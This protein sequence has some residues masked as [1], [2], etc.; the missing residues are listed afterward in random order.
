MAADPFLGVILHATGGLAAASFYLPYKAVRKWGWENYWLAGGLFAWIIA[1]WAISLSIIPDT[2]AI[3]REAPPRTLFWTWF[4][5]VLWGIGG[6]T[7][8]LT[9]RYLGIALGYALA[10]GLC[11]V[12]G[13]LIPPIFAGELGA[14]AGSLPG[15]VVLAG[16]FVCV[17][18]IACSGR[19]G[20][21][22]EAK[23]ADGSSQAHQEYNFGKGALVAVFAGVMSASMSFG[24]T[25][26]KPIGAI[27]VEHGAPELWQNLPVLVVVLLG[28]FMTNCTWCVYQ[29]VKKGSL[30]DYVAGGDSPFWGNLALCVVAGVTWYFQFFFYGMGQTKMGKYE[31]SSWTLH[32]ASIIIFGTVWGLLLREW[33][34]T[35]RRT[36]AWIAAGLALLIGS[37][38][39]VGYG[40]ALAADGGGPAAGDTLTLEEQFVGLP[41][42]AKRLTGPLFWLHGDESKERLEMYVEKV[43]EG[44]NG[45]FTAESRP[46]S[47]WLGEGWYRDLEIC[48]AAAKKHDLK[49]WIFDEMWWPSQGVAGKVPGRYATKKM[50]TSAVEV[51]GPT[52]WRGE[53]YGGERYIAA[54]AGRVAADGKI[55]GGSLVDMAGHITDG[56]L[57][58]DV[59]E[60]TWRI[61]KFTHVQGP[62]LGQ[63]GQLS[64]DGAS[65]DCVDWFIETVYQPH[66]DR[67]KEDFGMWIPG[68]FYDE[69]ET[70]GDWGTELNATLAEWGVDWKKAYV[71]YK[72]ELSGEKQAAAKYQY[73]DAFAETWGRTMYGTLTA[74]CEERGVKSIGHFMEHGSLY[75]HPEFCAGDMMRLQK[76]SSMGGIDAVFKQFIMGRKR[77]GHD[78]PMWQTPKLGS[79]ISHVYGKPDD[80]AMVEIFGARGQ[81]LTYPEMKWWIDHMQVSGIN[82]TIPH[83][84]NPRAP[85]DT[86][87]PPY[88]Y[89]GGHEPRW[90]LYRVLADYSSRLTLLLTG[91]R[92]VC[93]A[94]ILFGGN[95]R[96]VG[97]AV[98]PE[99]MTTAL[100]DALFD[101]DWLPFEVFERDTKLVGDEIAL[102]QERYKVLIVPPVEVIPYASLA[103]AKAF[104]D[105]GGVVVG[106]GFLPSKSATL[107]KTAEDIA[108][109]RT[110]IWGNA[111]AGLK[112]CRTNAAGG[113]SYLLAE[114][115]TPEDLTQALWKDAGVP[116]TVEVLE[117]ETNDWVHA[118]HRVKDGRDIFFIT[119]QN[120]D[121][122]VRLRAGLRAAGYPERWDA[123]RGEITSAAFE[124]RGDVAEMTLELEPFESV[125]I[126]FSAEQRALPAAV[127][128]AM[129][130]VAAVDV[131]RRQGAAE[132]AAAAIVEQEKPA[133][134]DC[135]WV[136][137]GGGNPAAAAAVGSCYFRRVVDIDTGK[138]VAS[139][140]LIINAD[141]TAVPF[142]NGV[143]L[144]DGRLDTWQAVSD[145]DITE[146][147][148]PGG[149]V[150]AV[151]V[152]NGGTEPNPAG[153]IGKVVVAFADG[154]TITVRIDE[155]W[156]AA[157]TAPA[158]WT[159]N[160]FDDKGWAAAVPFA[161]YGQSPWGDMSSRRITRSPIE[162]ADPFDGRFVVPAGVDIAQVR[163][164]L[165]M[166]GIAPEAAARITINGAYAGGVIERPLRLDV[167]RFMRAGENTIAIE[168]FAPSS[169]KV[170]FHAN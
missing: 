39:V 126:V 117:G 35:G 155:M 45:S 95:T 46:H 114:K 165:V 83:S 103:L 53:G 141:N 80:V 89:N 3:L 40:N 87:C 47:D 168:P 121:R 19:A 37:T 94:A 150:L 169:V 166:D 84:F 146:H 33:R 86:D 49:M 6:L 30:R 64:V 13:T 79:S 32:M 156:R 1:P 109:L 22:K 78:D 140:R 29:M 138:K 9:M 111:Q 85:Y 60:G 31:F 5:G 25:A 48:L 99:D 15:Q 159:A 152:V 100:Q 101:C 145:I 137:V 131:V 130:A 75:L 167:T 54:V 11:A 42:E 55:D 170:L 16:I 148:R 72:F 90:P 129:Q 162:K 71:A 70:R 41:M 119:N 104:F 76:Y 4:F 18:G 21:L 161:N 134:V 20:M 81:D 27:A 133:L 14:V 151:E 28:G 136:W 43:A 34:G 82:F 149:N 73:L 153:L 8:G 62:P 122:P 102:Y 58:W 12:F 110:G 123:M 91:G 7:F 124:R 96:R 44:G 88:F 23:L 97:K 77:V 24:L 135:R 105:A 17:L 2:F 98:M 127:D 61:M 142:V 120:I 38:L 108:V 154:G 92:H 125:A 106:Y 68:F 74:W 56:V 158:G 69:P 157:A 67:F 132:T 50:A 107:G 52:K 116:P 147:V 118:L 143:K 93:Q 160:D 115:P 57:A 139:A 128:G 65:R 112:A 113:R 36:G 164:V 66:Y 10:L 26:G 163:S 63:N 59:P 51:A 144:T